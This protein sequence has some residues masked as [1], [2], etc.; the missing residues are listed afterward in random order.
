MS[1]LLY[2]LPGNEGFTRLLALR[3]GW[4]IC[5][6]TVHRFPDGESLATVEPPPPDADIAL[7]CSL[8][9]PDNKLIPLL[10]A[11]DTL[12]EYA[13][14]RIAL[15]AAYMPYMRQDARFHPGEAVS[16]RLFGAW[17]SRH[18]DAVITVDP[19]LHRHATLMQANFTEGIVAH[20]AAELAKWIQERVPR[21]LIIGPDE[22]SQIWVADVAQ[23]IH[24]PFVVANKTRRDDI[25]VSLSF[26]PWLCD[27]QK[28]H[29]PVIVDDIISSGQT[30][31]ECVLRLIELGTRP[32]IC[33]AVH[34]V[35]APGAKDALLSAGAARIVTTNSIDNPDADIDVSGCIVTA[36]HSWLDM[37]LLP[38]KAPVP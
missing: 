20:A 22:E 36:M 33:T 38:R 3:C 12:R 35:F 25:H 17:L 11:A 9:H 14:R 4:T 7:V 34:G 23:R 5:A 18:F 30:M 1:G 32:P 24:A 28:D 15:I 10:M 2:A 19:H 13:P 29:T 16:S 26:P 31:A 37:P 27:A 6:M 8:D 21:P